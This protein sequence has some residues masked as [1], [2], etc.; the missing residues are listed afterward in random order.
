M[1][2]RRLY[3]KDGL[4][5]MWATITVV[6]PLAGGD[7]VFALGT[8]GDLNHLCVDF[9]AIGDDGIAFY[10]TPNKDPATYILGWTPWQ[11]P[12]SL[13]TQVVAAA[14]FGIVDPNKGGLQSIVNGGSHLFAEVKAPDT[15]AVFDNTSRTVTVPKSLAGESPRVVADGALARAGRAG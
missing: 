15:V 8:P 4:G 3:P 13:T 12:R 11:T 6:Q 9:T 14:A 10:V 5:N 7:P 1:V 2:Y